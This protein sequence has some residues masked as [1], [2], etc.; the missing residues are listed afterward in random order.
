MKNLVV[1]CTF[2]RCGQEARSTP[3]GTFGLKC[4]TAKGSTSML[5]PVTANTKCDEVVQCIVA[6]LTSL[7]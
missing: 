7:P 2:F 3:M 1:F 5:L 4:G 6:Q